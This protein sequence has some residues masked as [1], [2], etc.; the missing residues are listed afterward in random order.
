MDKKYFHESVNLS[1]NMPCCKITKTS[2]KDNTMES[3]SRTI[4]IH[5]KAASDNSLLQDFFIKTKKLMKSEGVSFYSR[6]LFFSFFVKFYTF[7]ISNNDCEQE[8]YMT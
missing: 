3:F 4:Y 7:L 5:V 2:G 1:V 6:V 8:Y